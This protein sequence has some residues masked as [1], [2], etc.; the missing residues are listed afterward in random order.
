MKTY[1][2]IINSIN[3]N[4]INYNIDELEEH[5]DIIRDTLYSN[6]LKYMQ[7]QNEINE[8]LDSNINIRKIILNELPN[9]NLSTKDYKMLSKI[10]LLFLES[11]RIFEEEMYYCGANDLYFYLNKKK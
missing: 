6:N 2:K 11:Q 8:I 5:L 9:S 7:L 10:F 3:N 4:T 1:K